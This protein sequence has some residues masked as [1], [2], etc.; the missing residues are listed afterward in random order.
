MTVLASNGTLGIEKCVRVAGAIRE[1]S[2]LS[3][4]QWL[5]VDPSPRAHSHLTNLEQ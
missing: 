3:S 4:F 5:Y 1:A 2:T